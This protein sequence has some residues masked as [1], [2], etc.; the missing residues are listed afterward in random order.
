MRRLA[1]GALRVDALI[2]ETARGRPGGGGR[3]VLPGLAGAMRQVK[4]W[5]TS[6]LFGDLLRD[7][8]PLGEDRIWV[9]AC[10]KRC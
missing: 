5:R 6:P 3:A 9:A 1:C 8:G 2:R 10:M 4:S 7:A